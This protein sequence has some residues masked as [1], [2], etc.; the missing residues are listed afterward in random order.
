[1]SHNTQFDSPF[2][3]SRFQKIFSYPGGID[4]YFYSILLPWNICNQ[5][6]MKN[7]H[8]LFISDN[9]FMF[10]SCYRKREFPIGGIIFQKICHIFDIGI[11]II[12]SHDLNISALKK[13]AYNGT[14][15]PAQTIDTYFDCHHTTFAFSL[16]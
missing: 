2:E 10:A 14:P 6:M 13:N 8:P 9:D 4:D 12:D 1:M 7:M 3:V 5:M 16:N 15:D 11:D